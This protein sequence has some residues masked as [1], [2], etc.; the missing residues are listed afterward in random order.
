MAGFD[1]RELPFR[2]SALP[3]RWGTPLGGVVSMLVVAVAALLGRRGE[4]ATALLLLAGT[5]LALGVVGRWMARRGILRLPAMRRDGVN[6]VATRPGQAPAVWLVAHLDSKSQPVPIGLRALGIVG[7]V[8]A[9]LAAASLAAAQLVGLD[10]AGLWPWVAGLGLASGVPVALTTVGGASAGAVDNASG[11]VAVVRAAEQLPAGANVGVLL[12]SAEELGLAGARAW[13][14]EAQAGTALNVDGVDDD[15]R[16]IAM[17][18]GAPP[19]APLQALDAA[20]AALPMDRGDVVRV[21]GRRLIPGILTDGVALADAGWQVITLSR[22]TGGTLRR[23]HTRR[24]DLGHMEGRSLETAAALLAG[25][26][27]RLPGT[28]RR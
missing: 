14:E 23:I 16:W 24:D 4:P 13:A 28:A 3:G 9:W 20:G 7:S 12:T 26:A 17:Y 1:V 19:A 25:A 22:G 18:T 15:G 11:A 8:A 21:R 10:A 5:G 2:Y 6:L 27:A